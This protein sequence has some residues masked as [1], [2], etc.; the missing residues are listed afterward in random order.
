MRV[1]IADDHRLV[2]DGI[3]R[4]LEADGGFE[5][6]G[7]TQTGRRCC[8]SSRARSPTSCCSTCGCRTWTGSPAST[9]SGR[10]HPDVK[11]VMLSAST[12]PELIETALRRG[13][14]AYVIKSVDPDDL[15][16]TL[17]QALEGNVHT[18]IGGEETE[19]AAPR[20]RPDRARDHDPRRTRARPLERGDR[21]GVLGRAADR[22]VPP[23]E[24]LPQARRE[25]PHRGDAHRVPARAGREPDLRRRITRAASA[26]HRRGGVHP[27]RSPGRLRPDLPARLPAGAPR[28]RQLAQ[29]HGGPRGR[30]ERPAEPRRAHRVRPRRDLDRPAVARAALHVRRVLRS[31][32]TRCSR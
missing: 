27:R 30:R 12:S 22:E 23:D 31:A 5:I 4:A 8:R 11:V 3:R 7:E 21:E 16:S 26:A 19:R 28:Q 2:L 29:P 14:A 10:R 24:H 15:P 9:R 32:G 25:E 20:R 18:A 13:A 6:V 1:V 17:R